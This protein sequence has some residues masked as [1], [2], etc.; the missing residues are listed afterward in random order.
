MYYGEGVHQMFKADLK[1]R[2]ELA[3]VELLLELLKGLSYVDNEDESAPGTHTVQD[4]SHEFELGLQ[5]ERR[6]SRWKRGTV[7]YK[8]LIQQKHT[9]S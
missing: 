4:P 9:D 8:Y 7:V 3:I 6:T 1:C 2:K 5:I